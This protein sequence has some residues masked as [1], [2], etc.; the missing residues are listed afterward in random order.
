MGQ[1]SKPPSE[2]AR[3]KR[4]SGDWT[5]RSTLPVVLAVLAGGLLSVGAFLLYQRLDYERRESAFAREGLAVAAALETA[6]N[7]DLEVLRSIGRFFA[8]SDEVARDEFGTFVSGAFEDH[9]SINVLG[10]VPRVLLKDRPAFEAQAR[11]NGLQGFRIT[12]LDK[13]LRFVPAGTRPEYYP[14]YYMLPTEGLQEGLGLDLAVLPSPFFDLGPVLDT[15]G[16]SGNREMPIGGGFEPLTGYLVFYPTFVKG[17]ALDTPTQRAEGLT[18]FAVAALRIDG[19]AAQAVAGIE[20]MSFLVLDKTPGVQ[21][22]L[23][24]RYPPESGPGKP[25]P[26]LMI[27]EDS[28]LEDGIRRGI[29]RIESLE[30]AGREW[31]L[32]LHP[33]PDFLSGENPIQRWVALSGGL[34][35]TVLLGLYVSSRSTRSQRIEDL[36]IELSEANQSM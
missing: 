30:I 9:T 16:G 35:A 4:G 5:P 11:L 13:S 28:A 20:G 22:R 27:G 29:H 17:A 19:L 24:Y 26:A 2:R 8:S 7:N 33:G 25:G 6:V 23:L 31:S 18:G 21:T 1:P 10:W 32:L 3:R 15:W 14:I 12:E 34:V 36:A